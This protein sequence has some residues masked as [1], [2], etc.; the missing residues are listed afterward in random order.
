MTEAEFKNQVIELAKR[1][2]WLIHHD[3]PAIR[4]NGSWATNTQGHAGFPDLVLAR[5]GSVIFAE[6]KSM[7]GKVTPGQT[8]WI[9]QLEGD[10]D[11]LK[12]VDMIVQVWRP[13]DMEMIINTLD[14]F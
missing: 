8:A 3:L 9:K 14:R 4:S 1:Y 12:N 6:L 10:P 11:Q 2:G 13:D 5:R 7:T